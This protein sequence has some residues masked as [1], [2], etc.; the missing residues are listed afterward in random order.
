L[1]NVMGR[2]HSVESFGALDGPG[3]RYVLFLQ[4]CAFRC[5]YCHNP[6]SWCVTSGQEIGSVDVLRD[7][8]RYKNF[9]KNGGVTLSG[10]EPL[11]QP[12]FVVSILEGCIEHK[13]HTA[14]DTAGGVSLLMCGRAVELADLLLLDIKAADDGLFRKIT[15]HSIYNT[16]DMLD[17]CEKIGKPVWIRHVL[18]PDLTLDDIQLNKLGKL[19]RHYDCIE[20]VELLPFHK[21]GEYK[22]EELKKTYKLYNTRTPLP[23]EV[24]HAKELLHGYGLPMA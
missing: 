15:G 5:V 20:R 24:E 7:I 3:I 14:I 17:F 1:K 4:G 10:G 23:Q 12:D 8:L 2:I 18:V 9:I 16:L 19:L 11:I 6:D 13:L 22:W 21:M